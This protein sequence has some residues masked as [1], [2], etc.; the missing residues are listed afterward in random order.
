MG[1]A[2]IGSMVAAR[3]AGKPAASIPVNKKRATAVPATDGS[4]DRTP[5]KSDRK[6]AKAGRSLL[7]PFRWPKR[8]MLCV[9]WLRTAPSAEWS[10]QSDKIN[11]LAIFDADQVGH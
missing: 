10:S 5:N 1:V 4:A 8:R 3:C 9:T 6:A 2:R 11:I 7:R